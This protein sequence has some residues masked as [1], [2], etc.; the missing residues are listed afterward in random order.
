MNKM[1]MSVGL[2]FALAGAGLL[3]A[4]AQTPAA[5][6]GQVTSAEE[7]AME[8]VLVSA[9]KAGSTVT[10]H[11]RQRQGRPLQ[12]P[13]GPGSSPASIRSASAPS[14]TISTTH[15]HRG[16]SAED[17]QRRSQAPQDRGSR[18]AA[19]ERR[20]DQQHSGHRPAEGALLNCVGCHTLERVVRST[21][22]RRRVH[23]RHAAAH[24]GLR[25][26]EHPAASAASQRRA[27]DG[28][29]RRPA[30]AGLSRHG[31]TFSAPSI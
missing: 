2:A 29:A 26:P 28:G 14:V 11:R 13:A 6:T 19:V 16:R 24:A 27:A 12:L 22:Q 9:K 25:E 4:G 8:G 10:D 20:M 31:A 1:L 15:E 21:P 3:P 30:R 17:H 23:Q 5:L 18:G 7:G